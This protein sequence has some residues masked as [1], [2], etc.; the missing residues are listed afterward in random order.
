LDLKTAHTVLL[1]THHLHN[2]FFPLPRAEL[3]FQMDSYPITSVV[4]FP[5]SLPN[6]PTCR[7]AEEVAEKKGSQ[8]AAEA[9][10]AA[11]ERE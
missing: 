5:L 10:A 4:P 7:D 6:G 9:A 11:A 1:S 8:I 3:S 2:I